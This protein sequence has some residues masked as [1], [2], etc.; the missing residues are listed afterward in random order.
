MASVIMRR[1]LQNRQKKKKPEFPRLQK[2]IILVTRLAVID[3]VSDLLGQLHTRELWLYNHSKCA[4]QSSTKT[5]F[6][7]FRNVWSMYRRM[8]FEI[9]RRGNMDEVR[10]PF[11]APSNKI[12]NIRSAHKLSCLKFQT[13]WKSTTCCFGLL[14]WQYKVPPLLISLRMT[15]P[16]DEIPPWIFF[17]VRAEGRKDEYGMQ[18]WIQNLLSNT[19]DAFWQHVARSPKTEGTYG[20]SKN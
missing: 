3:E 7:I 15:K 4:S 18:L 2:T 1:K 6:C 5:R 9:G 10:L 12:W 14:C 13:T 19:Q 17:H 11:S 16:K 8:C 20:G